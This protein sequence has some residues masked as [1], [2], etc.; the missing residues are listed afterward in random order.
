M[1]ELRASVYYGPTRCCYFGMW[2]GIVGHDDV[3]E[4]FRR[5]LEA[6]RLA[7][8]YLFVGPAGVGKRKFA[9]ELARSLLCLES[10]EVSL[11]PCGQCESCR[12]IAAGNHPDL[13]MVGLPKDKSTLPIELFIGDLEHR[14]QE[15]LCHRLGM[16]PFFG[17]RKVAIVDDADYFSPASANCLL[18]TLEEPPASALL[19]LIGTSPSRQLP[20]IRSRSQIVR[21]KA[22]EDECLADILVQSGAVDDRET[23]SRVAGLSEGS[24]ER[25]KQL[26]DPALW[27]FRDQLFGML[28]K[29][30]F[31]SVRAARAIQS[32]V[33]EVGKEASQKRDRLRA[34]LDFAMEYHRSQVRA[35]PEL[36]DR[37][38][39]ALDATLAATEHIDRNANVGL[40]IQWWCEALSKSHMHRAT[41]VGAAPGARA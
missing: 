33:D 12:M 35:I 13:D 37:F 1:L 19:I 23:A 38:V 14:N 15:G 5:T 32:F 24:L 10:T 41:R 9:I 30:R 18:K 31:D 8:T 28:Q 36:A 7:S 40:V 17:R 25:A 20:T 11:A 6:G 39:A 16:R 26:A 21:F 34:I 3:V 22:L 2:Q 29:P 4:R 27:S